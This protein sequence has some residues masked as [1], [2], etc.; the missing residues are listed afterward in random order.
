MKWVV[1][2]GAG[3]IGTN[4]SIHLT[5]NG[6]T[7]IIID[8]LSRAGVEENAR[9]LRDTYGLEIAQVDVSDRETFWA[10]L[11]AIGDFDHATH[12]AGQVSY[13]ASL[14]S[15]L[16]DFEIN[17]L[18]TLN[19]LEYL[20]QYMPNASLVAMSS[21][22]IYG[23]LASV[24]IVEERLRY[25]APDYPLG[26]SESLAVDCHGPYGCSKGLADQ[27]VADYARSFGLRT[28]SLRQSSVY[29]PHQHPRSDQGWVV[30]LLTE[31]L[32]GKEI[33]LNG[34]GKQVR[35]LLYV[36]DLCRLLVALPNFLEPSGPTQFN[37]GGGPETSLSLLE[38]FAWIEAESGVSVRYNV[39]PRRPSDQDVF[40]SDNSRVS[41]LTEWHPRVM[42]DEGLRELLMRLRDTKL[43]SGLR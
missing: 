22:K 42:P 15:P 2:G 1:T 23:D 27:Y 28:A 31:A 43:R 10:A 30:H 18:G 21:N 25:V 34:E 19:L 9:L 14:E 20:R 4:F 6:H 24:R 13:L 12:L 7:P 8:D 29:G 39:G 3:F 41:A 5:E 11:E 32:A 38:V 35:D 37:V 33:H 36:T 16:R 17:A 40:I 26:F